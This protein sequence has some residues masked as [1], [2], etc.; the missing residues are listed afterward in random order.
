MARVREEDLSRLVTD[1]K[2]LTNITDHALARKLRIPVEALRNAESAGGDLPAEAMETLDAFFV[3]ARGAALRSPRSGSPEVEEG[4]RVGDCLELLATL[5]DAS[6]DAVISDIPYGIA[7]DDWDVLHD[8]TNSALLG[9]SDAQKRAG[10]VFEKRRKPINGWSRADRQIPRQYY[11]WCRSWAGQWLRVL[12]PGGSALV[13]AGRRLAPRCVTALEDEGFNFRDMLAWQKP[14]AVFRAQRLSTVLEK[15][16]E[17]AEARRWEGW[18]VGNLAP[19]FEP[20]IWCFKPYEATIAD[21]VLEHG[22]GAMDVEAYAALTG[23]TSNVI[24]A[25]FEASEAGLHEAQ[26]P[27]ALMQALVELTTPVGALVVDPFAG[28]GST[29]VAAVRAGRRCLLFERDV[30]HAK[31]AERRVLAA[32]SN[33]GE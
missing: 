19:T 12:K 30:Q 18:R 7:H 25:G 32:R 11:D 14:R 4:V 9:A 3:S 31:T 13:F 33:N 16:G 6:V 29:G 26:K 22:L 10:K 17:L 1:V 2:R 24:R 21:N 8:N 5:P 20:I 23:D 27:V 15:R 28:S